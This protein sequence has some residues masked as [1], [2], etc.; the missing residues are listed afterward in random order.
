VA[1]IIGLFCKKAVQKRLYSAK[2][3]C[4]TAALLAT[5]VFCSGDS[6]EIW[7]GHDYR[8][9]LQKSSAKEAIF[10]KRDL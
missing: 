1:T 2:E 10:C 9:L 6:Q 8:A 7:G 5:G 3:T 4:N